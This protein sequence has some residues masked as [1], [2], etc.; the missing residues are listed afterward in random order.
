MS[1]VYEHPM[2][3]L[4]RIAM[5]L[6][7]LLM[8]MDHEIK[9]S[10][11]WSSRHALRCLMEILYVTDRTDLRT[12]IAQ[13][14]QMH[15]ETINP[16]LNKEGVDPKK[17]LALLTELKAHADFLHHQHGKFGQDCRNSHFLSPLNNQSQPGSLND[18]AHPSYQLWLKQTA[19]KRQ[20]DLKTWREAF[21]PLHRM[22]HRL[23]QLTRDQ[24][25]Y[26]SHQTHNGFFQMAL[27]NRPI[28]MIRIQVPLNLN[29]FPT[30]SVGR[31]RL[32]VRMMQNNGDEKATQS[33]GD[34]TFKLACCAPFEKNFVSWPAPS[35][36]G[37]QA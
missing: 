22:I 29:V 25:V 10:S 26:A 20:N 30:I 5:R 12:K 24:G 6:E 18:L 27:P 8:A 16:L 37:A 33:N 15:I 32:S 4:M 35:A 3:D 17:C 21:E 2:S 28:Q 9:S 11:P 19:A 34:I 23:L 13:A 1:I 14:M 7:Q 31:H 36:E